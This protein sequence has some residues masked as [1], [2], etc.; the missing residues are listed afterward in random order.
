MKSRKINLAEKKFS[1]L[2]AKKMK[3][4][5]AIHAVASII[6]LSGFEPG[7]LG[8]NAAALQLAPPPLPAYI[9]QSDA[10]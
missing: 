3:Q 6:N 7:S 8:Q 9:V 5:L 4:K 10:S 2:R 1:S